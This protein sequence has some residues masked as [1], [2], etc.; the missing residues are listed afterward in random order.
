MPFIP[1]TETE[2]Q[3]MLSAIG[4]DSIENLFDEIPSHLKAKGLEGV[5]TGLSEMEVNRLMS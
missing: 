4:V 2:I 3:D 5:P 1:H